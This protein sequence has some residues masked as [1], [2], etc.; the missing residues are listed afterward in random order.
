MSKHSGQHAVAH[1][2]TICS[3][4]VLA[5]GTDDTIFNE[6]SPL[7]RR[8]TT[9][10]GHVQ[11]DMLILK[12]G[13]SQEKNTH[14][15][16]LVMPGGESRGTTFFRTYREAVRMIRTQRYDLVS[17]QD[18]LYAGIIGYLVSRTAKVPLV[19]Q[20]HG[21][22]L[23]NPQ[24][25]ESGVGTFNRLMN[26]IGKFVLRRAEGVRAVSMRIVRDI[27]D[28]LGIPRTRVASIPIGSNDTA[29]TPG[30]G[31]R[32][33][34]L[35]FVGRLL[36]EKDPHLF[37]RVAIDVLTQHPSW[38]AAFAGDGPLRAELEAVRDAAGLTGRV[39]F[40]GPLS[41]GEL[42]RAYQTSALLVHTA[43]W[44][45]WGMPMIEAMAC[46][47]VVITNDTGCAGEAVR[48]NETGVVVLGD[49]ESFVTSI[50][51]LLGNPGRLAAL[52]K[53]SIQEV[54]AWTESSQIAKIAA[55]YEKVAQENKR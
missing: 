40:L 30:T 13:S 54:Q 47:C 15:G 19:V 21:D 53:A 6:S 43:G 42:A 32:D 31:P 22:Y 25:F 18:V 4:R 16:K 14:A 20:L 3:M 1:S 10:A 11:V 49:K 28:K 7:W 38:T 23:D 41:Q 34:T 27:T 5:I 29:F 33:T 50:E 52:Q 36:P 17:T 46:G 2:G 24:W 55:L 37:L 35:L 12:A 48:N 9:L 44:E 26:P 51:T 8:H 45:G 39:H